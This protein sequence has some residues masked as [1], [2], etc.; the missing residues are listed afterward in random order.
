MSQTIHSIKVKVGSLIAAQKEVGKLRRELQQLDKKDPKFGQKQAALQSQI[1]AT[2]AKFKGQVKAIKGVETQTKQLTTTAGRMINTFKSAAIAIASAFAVRAI[3]GSIK[4][5]IQVMADFE[6][7]MAAVRAISGATDKEFDKLEKSALKLG[8][9]TVFTA[10]QVAELQEEYAR[11]GF[12]TEEIIAATDATLDLAAATGESLANSAQTAGSVLRAFGYDAIQTQRIAETMASSFTNSALNLERFTESM[13]FAAPVAASVGFTVEE[14]TTML[15]KLADAG[16]HGSIAGNALKKIFL[17]IGTSG[18]KLSKKL[19]GPVMGI[20]QMSEALN[21]LSEEG[22]SAGDASELLGQRAAPAFLALIESADGLSDTNTMLS[23][24]EGAVSKMAAIRLNTLQGDITLMKSALEG[25]GLALGESVNLKL[26]Q[27]VFRFTEWIRSITNSPKKL[28]RLKNAIKAVGLAL[29][30]MISK[31]AVMGLVA[32]IRNMRTFALAW[33]GLVVQ[34]NAATGALAKF[35][36]MLSS[37]GIGLLVTVLGTVAAGFMT[38]KVATTEF[39]DEVTELEMQTQRLISAFEA[40]VDAIL[41]LD[42]ADAQRAKMIRQLKAEFGDTILRGIDIELAD[43]EQLRRL[44]VLSKTMGEMIAQISEAENATSTFSAAVDIVD[45]ELMYAAKKLT[46]YYSDIDDVFGTELIKKYGIEINNLRRDKLT[47]FSTDEITD[48]GNEFV[49]LVAM[50]KGWSERRVFQLV[51]QKDLDS[52]IEIFRFF[53]SELDGVI[54]KISGKPDL[55]GNSM[56]IA[57]AAEWE[58]D[59]EEEF[60][61]VVMSLLEES[62]WAMEQFG[63]IFEV[64][65]KEVQGTVFQK[66]ADGYS[67]FSMTPG[68]EVDWEKVMEQSDDELQKLLVLVEDF[69]ANAQK[70]LKNDPLIKTLLYED[71]ST[72]QELRSNF[73]DDL[74]DYRGW[75]E[76]A[77]NAELERMKEHLRLLTVAEEYYRLEQADR[78]IQANDVLREGAKNIG[79]QDIILEMVEEQNQALPVLLSET[80]RHF[81]NLEKSFNKNAKES[82]EDMNKIVTVQLQ[83]TK[84]HFKKLKKLQ[85]KFYADEFKAKME[86]IKARHDI[87]VKAHEDELDLMERNL[88]DLK[89][90]REGDAEEG[91]AVASVFQ[92][93]EFIK[94]N[95][96][97]YQAIKELDAQAYLEA[98]SSLDKHKDSMLQIIDNMIAE[99]QEKEKN[100]IAYLEQIKRQFQRDEEDLLLERRHTY[101]QNARDLADIELE[102]SVGTTIINKKFKEQREQALANKKATDKQIIETHQK[103]N[104]R[105]QEDWAEELFAEVDFWDEK[106]RLAKEGAREAS[107][108]KVTDLET[109]RD[110][111]IADLGPEPDETADPQAFADY[112]LKKVELEIKWNNIIEKERLAHIQRLENIEQGNIRSVIDLNKEKNDAI[113][114]V[115]TE[116]NDAIIDNDNKKNTQ[117]KTNQNDYD[118]WSMQST[119][120]QMQG[121]ID[122]YAQAFSA[123]SALWDNRIAMERKFLEENFSTRMDDLDRQANAEIESFEGNSEQQEI[124]RKKW[125][126]RKELEQEHQDMK[127]RALEEKKF[128]REKAN[129]IAMA[130]MNGGLAVAKVW[131]ETGPAGFA[132]APIVAALVAAQV[133]LIMAQEFVGQHGGIIPEFGAGGMV[134][135]PSHAKGGVKFGVGGRVV[136]L[137]GGEAVINKKSTAMFRPQLSAMNAAGGGVKFADGGIT[138]QSN[139]VM[140]K[141]SSEDFS[142]LAQRIIDGINDK[143]VFVTESSVTETQ[144]S[145]SVTE[146]NAVLF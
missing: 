78:L 43:D 135:G 111:E 20:E 97:K 39:S 4:G 99:E 18:S 3:V 69:N 114:K 110:D 100:N 136:E 116:A 101:E 62:E 137:E 38:A 52:D 51:D 66:L 141:N 9:S 109:Q 87:E 26:R 54:K 34:I 33:R 32:W 134:N 107:E 144:N 128:K 36:V 95:K 127:L 96:S 11:L 19:G 8:E 79:Q 103:T 145:I 113:E 90:I 102:M 48:Y 68:L 129:N 16:L 46:H 82:G 92:M 104:Q 25:L 65:G 21:I 24:T 47:L 6:A 56:P 126:K 125:E 7:K 67:T 61:P 5:V 88:K 10:R 120:E 55:R 42:R 28:Q 12:T 14:T 45:E 64:D 118:D 74:D 44:K 23:E 2:N 58:R 86:S 31:M 105:I 122:T 121:I 60:I 17:E 15:M 124:A 140:N 143:E 130:L 123:L 29:V 133:G 37:T 40:Q 71:D 117:L 80:L 27:V 89:T 81:S 50:F 119:E 76:K 72:R 30:F 98:T 115:T 84:N 146:S 77:Q 70:R 57:V 13:K 139:A 138:P 53:A 1:A 112:H 131:G 142:L 108:A 94:K 75:G 22:F 83:N 59:L 73:L 41:A 93:S 35:K 106:I 49:K 85:A 63:K 132:L 91:I